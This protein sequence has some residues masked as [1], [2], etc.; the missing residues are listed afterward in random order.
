MN[1]LTQEDCKNI[2]ALIN[3][4]SVNG[5]EVEG[6]AILKQKLVNLINPLPVKSAPLNK[7]EEPLDES[8]A[9]D[10]NTGDTTP[11]PTL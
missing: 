1:I 7:V 5:A 11:E 2:L 8:P 9:P 6:V 4:S 3:R 10:N